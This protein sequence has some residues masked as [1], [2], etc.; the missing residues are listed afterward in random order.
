MEVFIMIGVGGRDSRGTMVASF[1]FGLDPQT[2]IVHL[3]FSTLV[4]FYVYYLLYFCTLLELLVV[5][6]F[7]TRARKAIALFMH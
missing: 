4:F 5:M 6:L 1:L 3:L 2:I 7:W